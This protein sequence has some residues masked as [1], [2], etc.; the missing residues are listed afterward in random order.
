MRRAHRRGHLRVEPLGLLP[1]DDPPL[2]EPLRELLA[3]GR[4]PEDARRHQRLRVR[5][6]VLLVVAV[7]PIAD[8]V[9]DDVVAEPP[10]EREREPDRRDRRLGIVG[11]DVDDRRVE[12]LREVAR[13]PRRPALLGLR[14]EADLI[15]RDE[16]ERAARRVA[17]EVREVER[18]GDHALSGERGIAVDEDRECDGRIVEPLARRAVGLVGPRPSL[19]DG[20][21]RLEVARVRRERDV[22]LAVRRDALAVRAEVVLHVAGAALGVRADRL[23]HPLALELAQD[24]LVRAADDV[25]EH[26]ETAAVRHADHGLV[27]TALGGE[28]DRLVEH[29]HEHVEPLD[30][31]LLLPEERLAQICLEPADLGQAGQE[32]ELLLVGERLAVAAGLD[33]LAEPDALL[34][35]G[36]VLDLVRDRLAIRL[37]QPGQRVRERV[38]LDVCPQQPRRDARLQLRRQLRVHALRLERGIAGR[39][40]AE[41]VEA[42]CEMPVRPV[43]LDERHRRGDTFEQ[44]VVDLGRPCLGQRC[45]GHDRSDGGA[46]RPP[47][48][49]A[50]EAGLQPE[51]LPVVRGLEERTPLLGDGR[52]ILEILLEQLTREARVQRVDVVRHDLQLTRVR[53]Q[54]GFA[55]PLADESSEQ[56]SP[57]PQPMRAPKARAPSGK[58]SGRGTT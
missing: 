22:D 26:V 39:L 46:V 54:R 5:G 41:R 28:P 18:L 4:V 49:Q 11:V 25:R 3:D 47:L 9:D 42:R 19:D 48:E 51:Q 38:S 29:R 2:L 24:R 44:L 15:V 37:L 27:R 45:L 7:P 14:R 58:R 33:R 21:D 20:I 6:L 12:A 53:R 40:G 16:V 23:E 34:E 35:I 1:G 10:A 32:R 30:R 52:R 50:D 55:A 17:V 8:E 57:D 36:D 56:R 43:R 31:K 13:I